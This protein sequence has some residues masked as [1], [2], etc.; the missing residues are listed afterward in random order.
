MPRTISSCTNGCASSAKP[1]GLAMLF[2][3]RAAARAMAGSFTAHKSL[4]GKCRKLSGKCRLRPFRHLAQLELLDLPGARL[5]HFAEHHVTRH[6]V[7]REVGLAVRDDVVL[8]RIRARL[9]FDEGARGLA[10]AH[11]MRKD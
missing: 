4:A 10:P 5:R 11:E 6:L 7:A 9:E 2:I 8:G 1:V 3:V